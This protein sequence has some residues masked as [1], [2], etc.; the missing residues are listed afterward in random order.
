MIVGY[1]LSAVWLLSLAK[2]PSAALGV[3]AY[4]RVRIASAFKLHLRSDFDY[5]AGREAWIDPHI[6]IMTDFDRLPAGQLQPIAAVGN[7]IRIWRAVCVRLHNGFDWVI[8]HIAV[9]ENNNVD[10]ILAV[11]AL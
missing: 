3:I 10:P 4:V 11:L 8:G 5:L 7:P 1:K 9:P 2:R 6:M